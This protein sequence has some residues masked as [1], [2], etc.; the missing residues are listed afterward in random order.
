MPVVSVVVAAYQVA[1]YLD[2]CLTSIRVQTMGDLEVIVVDDGSTDGSGD[3]A[4]A[5]AA[6]DARLRVVHQANHGL[7]AARNAGLDLARGRYVWFVDGDDFALPEMLERLLERAEATGL[8]VVACDYWEVRGEAAARKGSFA[9][10]GADVVDMHE[11]WSRE[12]SG[13]TCAWSAMW[14]KLWRREV[15][16]GVRFLEGHVNEDR[17]VEV[18][19]MG[20]L[21]GVGIVDEPLYCY[22]VREGSITRA[23]RTPEHLDGA[24]ALLARDP[25]FAERGWEDL[26]RGNLM[27]LA[28]HMARAEEGVAGEPA[29]VRE[30]YARCRARTR[31]L[32]RELLLHGGAASPALLSRVVPYLASERLYRWLRTA[33]LRR[34]GVG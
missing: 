26:R 15:W 19:L 6:A 1:P 21:P 24:E 29:E 23:A 4:D 33:A 32:C 22:R 11:F 3:I 28:G 17:E 27:S 34:H 9:G 14:N 5:H 13:L 12:Y 2:E 18:R 20:G 30:R 25:W 10:L 8:P 7:S 31:A 16:G